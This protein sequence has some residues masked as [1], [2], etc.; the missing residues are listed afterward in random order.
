M[1]GA[2]QRMTLGLGQGVA[3]RI[4]R[5]DLTKLGRR[6]MAH[7]APRPDKVM[8]VPFMSSPKGLFRTLSFSSEGGQWVARGQLKDGWMQVFEFHGKRRS[9]PLCRGQIDHA[10]GGCALLQRGAG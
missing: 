3:A 8:R 7:F 9:M 4:S 10:L 1:A 5:Q 6:I 2:Y